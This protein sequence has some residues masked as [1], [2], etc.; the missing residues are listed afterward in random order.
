MSQ[1]RR[2]STAGG[3]WDPVGGRRSTLRQGYWRSEE[4][5]IDGD[6]WFDGMLADLAAARWRI[7]FEVYIFDDDAMGERM[8][9]ALRAAAERGVQVRLMVD[10]AGSGQW[11]WQRAPELLGSPL[12]LR[13]YHPLPGQMLSWAFLGRSRLVALVHQ[14]LRINRRNHRKVTI[15]DRRIAWVGSFNVSTNVLRSVSGDNAWYDAGARVEGPAIIELERAFTHAWEKAWRFNR[16]RLQAPALRPRRPVELESGLVRLNHRL[17]LRRHRYEELIRRITGAKRRIWIAMAYFVPG[18]RLVRALGDAVARGV[19]VRLMMSER[20]DVPFMPWVALCFQIALLG[21]GVRIFNY[22]P[23]F[24]HAKIL[25]IDDWLCVGST[26]LNARSLLHDLEA[27]VVLLQPKSQRRMQ[28]IFQADFAQ[29]AE[30]HHHDCVARPWHRR[31]LAW[32]I[33]K[34]RYY[35]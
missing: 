18:R 32:C 29:C 33:L 10:G 4:L 30:L 16:N 31:C 22:L 20:S 9:A 13:V 15:I 2:K 35:L 28:E 21:R 17:R 7:D 24:L 27:D 26:N 34:F 3:E 8:C 19:D 6:Q 12:A 25:L 23:R 1:Q 11:L 14:V 5:Y